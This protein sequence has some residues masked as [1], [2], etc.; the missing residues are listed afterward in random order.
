MGDSI[1]CVKDIAHVGPEEWN[2]ADV[3]ILGSSTWDN[4]T[5]QKDWQ[6]FLPHLDS[7]DLHG[8]KIALFGLGDAYGFASRF[9]NG[10]RVLYDKVVERGGEVIGAWPTIGYDFFDTNAV[11]DG[12]FVGLVIDQEN[13]S[14]K[15]VERV[16]G[17]VALLK[18]ELNAVRE[19]GS[20][21]TDFPFAR[22]S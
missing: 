11:I 6:A 5:L 17:W 2:D 4:G 22:V 21:E 14:D 8:K 10:L 7:M 9:V 16:S 20:D 1:D 13:A 15:T 19:A 12:R 3:L 18:R